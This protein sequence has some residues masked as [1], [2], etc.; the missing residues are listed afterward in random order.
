MHYFVLGR[1]H[2]A[3]LCACGT[4]LD[5]PE[6]QGYKE[7]MS[8]KGLVRVYSVTYEGTIGPEEAKVATGAAFPRLAAPAH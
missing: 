3:I 2:T 1:T 6:S 7:S 8:G 5:L 4:G